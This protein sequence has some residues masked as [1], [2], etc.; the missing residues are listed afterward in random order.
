[1][2]QD[3]FGSLRR[4][5]V[6][7][8][9]GGGGEADE[10]FADKIGSYLRKSRAGIF[11]R[12]S[13]PALPPL[14][15]VAMENAPQIRWRKGELIGSGAF[16]SVY[17]GMN[18]DSGELLAVKQVLIGT[19]NASKDKA[20]AHIQELEE[21]VM[22]LKNLSHPNIVRYLGTA[23]EEGTLNIFLELVPGGS[24][25][26]LLGKFGSFPEAVIRKYTKELL[27]GLEYLHKNGIMHRDIKGAN[28]LVDK[29]A[30]KLADFG[31]SKKVVE[32][33]TISGAKSIKGTPYWMA[34]EVILQTG[35][36]FS[37]D[38]WSVGCTIIE[39]ATGK[40]PWSQQYQAVAVLFHIGTTKSHPPIPEHLSMD[41]KDF[42]QKCLQKEPNLRPTASELL[43]HPFVTGERQEVHPMF[44]PSSMKNSVNQLVT[45][46]SNLKNVIN[47]VGEPSA[48]GF[49]KTAHDIGSVRCSTIYPEK[50]PDA[51]V[52]GAS[53]SD[54]D[55][56]RI[57]D[58]DDSLLAGSV[59]FD[60]GFASDDLNKSFNPMCEPSDDWPCK[61]DESPEPDQRGIK[62]DSCDVV[63]RTS[64][65]PELSVQDEKDFTFPCGQPVSE[66]DDE[67][68]ESKIRA[69]LDE[70]AL[71]LKKLQT[72]LYEE[73]YNTL[74]GCSPLCVTDENANYLK[75]P[76]KSKS[77]CRVT[78][79]T[80]FTASDSPST[81]SPGSCSRRTSNT[82][83]VNDQCLQEIPLH[84]NNEWIGLHT[85]EKP[86]SSRAIKSEIERKWK[87]ELVQELE[88]K[89]ELMRRT[90]V[91]GKISSPKDRASNRQRD[92]LPFA[93]P[94]K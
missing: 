25:S 43:Q 47:P 67:V 72:P 40:P 79:G 94:G 88:S 60:S 23:R 63:A 69:F 17:M 64:G 30:C 37:A 92:R 6:M 54:D 48:C 82:G 80:S 9:G 7:R 91:G 4:S 62:L 89:R 5:L 68:T 28:I 42:L 15:S 81:A 13:P 36:S 10:G 59:K 84:Q 27:L 87:E 90:G 38:I 76:P 55:M 35:H 93:S 45:S 22:L 32:L 56:C 21:E 31:A 39:M 74:N 14:K 44:S 61:F 41:A 53:I 11:G 12:A 52:W 65:D 75:L 83:A 16:G 58:K 20:Q 2:I 57:D 50:F 46:G 24:I 33:A 3:V 29:E 49:V 51:P 8:G 18:L 73:F 71:D 86:T 66:E 78:R 1:M 77:P 70:K 34:P 26:S 19:N 85:P